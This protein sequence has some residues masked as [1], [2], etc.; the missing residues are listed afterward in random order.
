MTVGRDQIGTGTVLL[1]VYRLSVEPI[2]SICALIIS[3]LLT[4]DMCVSSLTLRSFQ[5]VP[6][7][8]AGFDWEGEKGREMDDRC[9]VDLDFLLNDCGQ[10]KPC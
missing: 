9:N 6:S 7:S 10:R 1:L 2:M 4:L 5:F 3:N 8:A